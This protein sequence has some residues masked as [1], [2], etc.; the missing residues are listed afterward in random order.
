LERLHALAS[1]AGGLLIGWPPAV[2]SGR[3]IQH[4]RNRR[5]ALHSLRRRYGGALSWRF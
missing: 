5:R 1:L 4:C 3:R 2:R